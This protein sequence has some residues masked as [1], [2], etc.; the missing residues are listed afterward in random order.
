MSS[1]SNHEN[2]FAVVALI[3]L[4]VV[5]VA[6]WKFPN[7]IDLN[8][9]TGFAIL[10]RAASIVTLTIALVKLKVLSPRAGISALLAGL[11]CAFFPGLDYW[12]D[13]ELSGLEFGLELGEPAW[14]ARWQAKAAFALAPGMGTYWL[15]RQ[16][17]AARNGACRAS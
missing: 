7:A 8:V 14:Y 15:F 6:T 5:A 17:A 4:G 10:L 16:F 13:R 12:S 11:A 1:R 9:E 3:A 2:L